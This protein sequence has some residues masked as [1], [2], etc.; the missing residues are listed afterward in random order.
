MKQ[1]KPK[2]PEPGA[3]AYRCPSCRKTL[4]RKSTKAWV[5]SWCNTAQRDV[6]LVR[7]EP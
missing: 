3:H 6:H 1:D 4:W 5:K 2:L 7:A